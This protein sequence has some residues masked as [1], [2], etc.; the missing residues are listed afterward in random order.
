MNVSEL[1]ELL[2]KTLKNPATIKDVSRLRGDASTRT[3]YRVI[4]EGDSNR[5]GGPF[6]MV[7]MRY[8]SSHVVE[9]ELAFLN[10]HRYLVMA[11]ISIPR[12]YL[13]IPEANL[14]LLE[15]SGD[16]TLE[17]V[18]RK[19]GISEKTKRI[20]DEAIDQ[21]V[22]IQVRG[23][24]CLD[25]G[26]LAAKHSFDFEKLMWEM[27][28]FALWGLEKLETKKVGKG[29][30]ENF[31]KLIEP[32][33]NDLISLPRMLVHRDYHSRNIMVQG[34]ESI[35]I[36][37]F[38]DARMGN[39]YYDPASLLYDSYVVLPRKERQRLFNRY[40]EQVKEESF[41]TFSSGEENEENLNRMAIQ[42]NLKALGTF[43]YMFH[44][45][46]NDR[47]LTYIPPTILHLKDNSLLLEKY[48]E[49]SDF[50]L[51]LLSELEDQI[52]GKGG[53]FIEG[54][55]PRGG[56]GNQAPASDI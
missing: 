41:S 45:R 38:Q 19:S 6:S 28:F 20:Y 48:R 23:T 7:L 33:I 31:L 52:K 43:F 18:V 17:E 53:S 8:P 27:D 25:S 1:Q 42:R 49:L 15:D 10:A 11:G 4:L 47:Y 37:D 13:H 32:V 26:A 22:A 24:K 12:I 14:L 16:T 39:M 40:T 30:K 56:A 36:I 29:V 44:G 50:I 3:Y 46:K 55:D 21:I 34:D 9:G 2:S 35:R 5:G 54:H 51:P